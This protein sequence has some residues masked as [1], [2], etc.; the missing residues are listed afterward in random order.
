MHMNEQWSMYIERAIEIAEHTGQNTCIW[1]IQSQKLCK[2][3][4]HAIR[5]VPCAIPNH[6]NS[7]LPW[8][9]SVGLVIW[10][11]LR[12]RARYHITRTPTKS[13]WVFSVGLATWYCAGRAM[14]I[15]QNTK[16]PWH[17]PL[18]RAWEETP[19]VCV[20]ISSRLGAYEH[21]TSKRWCSIKK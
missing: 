19:P 2:I 15:H 12:E 11:I 17:R 1:P 5:Q 21:D 3:C 9:F 7:I 18:A 16:S 14:P 10:C 8:V 13:L 20:Y 4:C 6:Q